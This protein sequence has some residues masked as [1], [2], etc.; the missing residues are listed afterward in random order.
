M[1]HY[2][3]A[4][5][6]KSPVIESILSGRSLVAVD[7]R[8][9]FLLVPLEDEDFDSLDLDCSGATDGFVHLSPGFME[10]CA[11]Q[12]RH[13]PLVYLETEYFGG[14]GDQAAA[15]FSNGSVLRPTPLSGDGSINA[16]LRMIGVVAA[17]NL[18]EFDF[19]GLSRHRNTSVWKEVAKA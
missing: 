8:D 9:G 2:V 4:I 12:S 3:T 11:E 7:L 15:A 17:N 10:F 14:V 13:G 18:D 5:I 1:G 19:I 6:G 16:A